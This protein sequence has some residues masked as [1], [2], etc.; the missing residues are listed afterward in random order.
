MSLINLIERYIDPS[1][2]LRNYLSQVALWD[3]YMDMEDAE[4]LNP[5]SY[6]R[7]AILI[8][9]VPNTN[10]DDTLILHKF[11]NKVTL[12]SISF[13]AAKEN[14]TKV[15]SIQDIYIR[16]RMH[17]RNFLELRGT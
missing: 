16:L 8:L 10:K 3:I 14:V 9:I 7:G 17:R 5:S 1:I 13:L 2:I 15:N 11:I 6:N 4:A 12:S